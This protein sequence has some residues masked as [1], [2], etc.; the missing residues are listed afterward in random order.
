MEERVKHE[1]F[2]SRSHLKGD[3]RGHSV[4]GGVYAILGQGMVY[5][6]QFIGIAILGRLLGPEE[7]GLVA[8]VM[9]FVGL[10]I[11]FNN[12]GLATATVQRE[13]ITHEQASTLFW[14]NIGVSFFV[15]LVVAVMGPML[16]WYYN[17]EE[18]L[19]WLT[20][21]MS[22]GVVV[23][24]LGL[25]HYALLQRQMRLEILTVLSVVRAVISLSAGIVIAMWGG[26][27]WSLVLMPLAGTIFFTASMWVACPWRPGR[28]QAGT[29]VRGMIA[30]GS[31]LTGFNIVNHVSRTID[32]VLVGKY[33]GKEWLG[34]YSRAYALMRL[35]TH[36]IS[37]SIALMA[38]PMLSLLQNEPER[39][40]R[41]Y[42]KLLYLISF[43][44]MPITMFMIVMSKQVIWLVIGR[45]WTNAA[46]IFVMLGIAALIQ[47]LIT[48]TSWLYISRGQTRRMFNW[49]IVAA[50]SVVVACVIGLQWG[51]YGVASGYAI[52][53][54]L[55][56]VPYMWYA[57]RSTLIKL[58]GIGKAIWEPVISSVVSGFIVMLMRDYFGNTRFGE[59]WTGWIVVMCFV[60][61]LVFYFGVSCVLT[62]SFRPII[63]LLNLAKEF[64]K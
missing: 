1:G 39:Y 11:I 37:I 16:A 53:R 25:E 63:Q 28:F 59:L 52:C 54:L 56:F 19:I 41:Y 2:F 61:M 36:L 8:M 5:L 21:V 6:T 20:L 24:G 44:S 47:P 30:F 43:I 32:D 31:Y 35:P 14:I 10:A 9:P 33:C 40:R 55:S 38:V 57:T 62:F 26:G 23:E 3:L 27:V 12:V 29:G 18:K 64:K 4:R 45:Q 13:E 60:V 51:A 34:Q 22:I 7:Y 15:A 58:K 17:G 49:E 50:L 48:T 46:D 42:L